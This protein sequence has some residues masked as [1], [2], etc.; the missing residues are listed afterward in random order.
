MLSRELQPVAFGKRDRELA[1]GVCWSVKKTMQ[2]WEVHAG[3]PTYRKANKPLRIIGW[4]V[5][6][7]F[8]LGYLS[9]IALAAS[10]AM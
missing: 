4:I 10:G 5:A 8:V 6:A 9:T 3:H 2:Y 1:E 7:I